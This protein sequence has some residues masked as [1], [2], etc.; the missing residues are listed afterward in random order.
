MHGKRINMK[1]GPQQFRQ[2]KRDPRNLVVN[3]KET[4]SHFL[5]IFQTFPRFLWVASTWGEILD[6]SSVIRNIQR[7][8]QIPTLTESVSGTEDYNFLYK[9]A[10]MN[11][12]FNLTKYGHL[13]PNRRAL[14]TNKQLTCQRGAEQTSNS[15][16]LGTNKQLTSARRGMGVI[17]SLAIF[18]I[19]RPILVLINLSCSW[20]LCLC[21]KPFIT[22]IGQ[23]IKKWL[24]T[25]EDPSRVSLMWVSCL[26]RASLSCLFVFSARRNI[27]RICN[28]SLHFENTGHTV[29]LT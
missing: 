3:A 12:V 18:F 11:L 23:T 5:W 9:N 29:Q 2:F 1:P 4:S 21:V 25:K 6:S 19:V 24:A 13:V 28:R 27:D 17:S 16:R 7:S 20:N 22:W 26:F 15:A 14:K 8:F 10:K